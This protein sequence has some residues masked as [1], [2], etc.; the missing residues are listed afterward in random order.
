MKTPEIL[1]EEILQDHG[2]MKRVRRYLRGRHPER[3]KLVQ[4]EKAWSGDWETIEETDV[5]RPAK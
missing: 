5:I 2:S 4:P 3:G 1:S